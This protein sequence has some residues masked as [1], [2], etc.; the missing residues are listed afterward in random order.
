MYPRKVIEMK[1]LITGGAGFIGGN[2]IRYIMKR[3]PEDRVVNLDLL[4]YAGNTES[5]KWT[6]DQPN[7]SF[8]RGDIADREF[9]FRLFEQ[10]RFDAVV[11]FAAETHVDRSI[12][13]PAVFVQTNVV[14]TTTLLDAAKVF[15][16][17]RYHQVSTDEVYG[18]LPLDRSDLFFTERMPLRPSSP[19][20]SSKAS[21]DL[22]ALAYHRTFG[23]SVTVSRCSNNYGPW[24]FPEKLIPL[25]ISRALADAEIPVYGDGKNVRDWLHAADHCTAID[26]ILRRGRDGEVYN[27]G[28]HN[29]RSN[30]EVIRMI[31][32]ILNKPERLIRFVADRPGHDR[33]YAIDASKLESELGWSA[34]YDFEEGLRQTVRW[35][36]DHPAW[37]EKRPDAESGGLSATFSCNSH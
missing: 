11:N 1:L 12:S 13:D 17:K 14:G 23:L 10:E 5:L 26:Q 35:Y 15:G 19:Y 30:L 20:S 25:T 22:F 2:F 29:A 32:R 37:R 21:A 27:V 4:T 9:V 28:G 16:V 36:L 6:A 3:Y 34:R 33:R 31:L 8:V 7:Y 24:Q 18:D